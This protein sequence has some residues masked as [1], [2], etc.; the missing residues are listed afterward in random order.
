LAGSLPDVLLVVISQDG[1]AR[2]VRSINGAVTV[3]DQA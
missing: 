3:W 1:D 2:F